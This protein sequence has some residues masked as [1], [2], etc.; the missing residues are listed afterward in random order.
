[1]LGAEE[2]P[3]VSGREALAVFARMFEL[4]DE[5]LPRVDRRDRFR[6]ELR[7]VHDRLRR[8]RDLAEAQ[9]PAPRD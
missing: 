4:V 8:L 2:D 1:V 3:P 9:L 7:E 5:E 6:G